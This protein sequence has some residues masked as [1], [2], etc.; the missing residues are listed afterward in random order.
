MISHETIVF[1]HL[2]NGIGFPHFYYYGKEG[3]YQVLVMELLGP[4]LEALLHY[5]N[6]HFSIKT[7]CMLAQEMLLRIQFLHEHNYLHRDLKPEHFIIGIENM[8]NMVY[9]IDYSLCKEYQDPV[10]HQ[11]IPY[12]S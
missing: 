3:A 4:S 11:H 6:G 7:V 10:L 9:L 12:T 5:C 1:Q 8:R 2:K